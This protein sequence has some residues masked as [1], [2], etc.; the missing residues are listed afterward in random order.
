MPSNKEIVA[1]AFEKMAAGDPSLYLDIMADDIRYELVGDNSWGRIYNGKQAFREELGRPLMSRVAP[2]LKM[3]VTRILA[4]GDH[5]ILESAGENRTRSGEPYNNRYCMIMRMAGGRI[6]DLTEY[7]DTD[8]VL[9]R[10]GERVQSP[11]A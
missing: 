6:V 11:E 3:R 8:L 4:D 5:V 2:P 1:A 7:T 10:L 9:R